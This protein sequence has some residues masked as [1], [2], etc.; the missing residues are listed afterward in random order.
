MAK[1]G[2][3]RFKETELARAVRAAREAGGV[4]RV[5]IARDGTINVILARNGESGRAKAND[6]DD[7]WTEEI[8]KLKAKAAK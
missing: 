3:A 4:E 8:A 2:P 1:R 7:S 5:E 6:D